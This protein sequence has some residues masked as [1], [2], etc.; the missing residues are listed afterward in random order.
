MK[1]SKQR[2]HV[3][4]VR[5]LEAQTHYTD[6][7][8]LYLPTGMAYML[9]ASLPSII[10]LHTATIAPF[11]FTLCGTTRN[12]LSVGACVTECGLAVVD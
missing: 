4:D 2:R 1:D 8:L 6:P 5:I 3:G 9:L 11:F 7:D 12:V 10:G